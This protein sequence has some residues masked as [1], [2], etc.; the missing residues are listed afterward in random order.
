MKRDSRRNMKNLAICRLGVMLIAV[1]AL[2]GVGARAQEIRSGEELLR[3]MHE[4]YKG[5]WYDTLTFV[6][7]STT[8]NP[9]GTSKIETWYE[10][11]MLPGKLRIDFGNVA[12]GNGVVFADG[13]VTSFKGGQVASTRAF[14]HML[15]VL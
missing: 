12:D 15:L 11:A 4:R 8:H 13:Q 5:N 2:A 10:A 7:K 3:A 14:V 9:D 6:Q 1:C